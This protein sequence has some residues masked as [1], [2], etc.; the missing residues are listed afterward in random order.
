MSFSKARLFIAALLWPVMSV[1]AQNLLPDPGFEADVK[2][3][4]PTDGWWVY[5]KSG[6]GHAAVDKKIV[7]TGKQSVRL[8]GT[9]DAR[10]VFL[11][12][13]LEVASEDEIV[14]S[15]WLRCDHEQ[16]TNRA[17]LVVMFR[18]RDG[19]I[20]DR[21]RISPLQF[22]AD[23]WIFLKATAKAP[24]RSAVADFDVSCSNLVGCVW[25]DDVSA[26]VTSPQSMFMDTEPKPW[27]GQHE[28]TVRIINREKADFRGTLRVTT[29]ERT[30]DLPVNIP[31]TSTKKLNVSVTL[32]TPGTHHYC[33]T[34]LDAAGKQRRSIEGI[35]HTSQPLTVFPACPSYVNIAPGTSEIRVDARVIVNPSECAGLR[36]AARIVDS[37][38]KEIAQSTVDASHGDFVGTKLRVPTATESAYTISVRLLARSGVEIANGET[39]VHVHAAA[40]SIVTTQPNGFLRVAGQPE[41]PIGLY[42]CSHYDEMAGAGFSAT[43]SYGVTVGDAADPINAT[44]A[45]VKR[46]LDKNAEYH[47]RM[48]VEL[49]R[50]AIEKAQWAQIRRRIKTFRNHPGL[51]CWGSEE[52]VARSEAP[53]ANIAALYKLVHKLDPNHPLVLG[54]TRDIIQHLMVDRRN[55][56]PD[57]AMDA[58]IWWWY[59]I[60]LDGADGE[61]LEGQEKAA[62]M[63]QPPSWLTTTTSKKPLWIAIQSYQHP[64][65]DARFPTPAEYR[66]MAYLSIINNVRGLWFYTG[67]GQKDFYGHG[68]GILNKPE[69]GHWD[70]VRKLVHELR[71]LSP[72]I[73]SPAI[74][75]VTQSPAN[76]AIQFS[77]HELDHKLYLFAANKSSQPQTTH[78]TSA[79]FAQKKVRVLYEEHA[80]NFDGSALTDNFGPFFVHVYVFE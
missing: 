39:D 41:F 49:P 79:A 13:K 46:L 68:A 15:G 23:Q 53:L 3:G 16:D 71:E 11:S 40:D 56:F 35:F 70:Y 27:P 25:A 47:M 5:N 22:K 58:G 50:H 9:A 74:S 32:S 36:L 80:G 6:E 65:K 29:D 54:D 45:D 76:P 63:L 73:M 78:F 30:S 55:F 10:F 24:P 44:D 31:R 33:I 42:S 69:E 51:L 60:P 66:C 61:A 62:K 57:Q 77:V 7:H 34:L 48:M 17:G 75:G 52:R 72:V 21:A 37:A 14:F 4:P 59:P 26:V 38:G 1:F 43:H 12:P 64:K 20:V 2:S 18:A 67:S 8:S 19:R 28:I